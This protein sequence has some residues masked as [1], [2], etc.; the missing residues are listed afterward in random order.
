MSQNKVLKTLE[1]L[2]LEQ[3]EAHVYI[4]LG[5]KGPQ[6]AIDIARALRMPKQALYPVLKDLQ[7]KGLVNATIERPSRFSAEPFERVMDLF[8]K[9]KMEE[10]Q[11]IQKNKK[12]ILTDWQSIKIKEDEEKPSVFKVLEGNNYIYPKLKQMIEETKSQL[13]M[14]VTIPELMRINQNEALDEFLA[15]IPQS[16]IKLRLLTEFTLGNIK[17]INTIFPKKFDNLEVRVPEFGLKLPN[18]MVIR[19]EDEVAFIIDSSKNNGDKQKC[20]WTNCKALAQ[21]FDSVFKNSWHNAIDIHKKISE[22]KKGKLSSKMFVIK[23]AEEAQNKYIEEISSAQK[24]IYIISSSNGLVEFWMNRSQ[25]DSWIRKGIYVRIM[26][27]ITNENLAAAKQLMQF[28]EVKHVPEGYISTTIIDKR[29]LFQFNSQVERKVRSNYENTFYTDD[30]QFIE[31]MENM[32]DNIWENAHPLSL[33]LNQEPT[34]ASSNI[35]DDYRN[36]FK[37]I[38]GLSYMEESQQNTIT[39][40]EVIKKIVNA[41]RIPAKDPEKDVLRIYCTLGTVIIYPEKK[42]NLP[43]L[44]VQVGCADKNSAFGASNSISISVQTNIADQQSYLQS[45]FITD[46]PEGYDFR[47]AMCKNQNNPETVCLLDKDKLVVH[48]SKN[49]L[50]AGWTVPIPLLSQKYILPPANLIFKSTGK[51]RTYSTELKSPLNRRLVYEFNCLN[52]FVTFLLPSSSYYSPATDGL[53][54]RECIITSYPPSS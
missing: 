45:T 31:K 3:P 7:R 24:A 19:D 30:T 22:I 1:D 47:K 46:N 25:T 6:K 33:T 21:S 53:F 41:V 12:E 43:N 44:L 27:P 52:A 48:L 4:F 32:L 38:L 18:S 8:V 39:E 20:L 23:D 9:E 42:F 40:K 36:E 17:I 29:H 13:L 16:S 5:K 37:K 54:Y 15:V 10:A 14:V 49:G 2:G 51:T 35:F 34:S 26:A 11:R 50:L 28:C